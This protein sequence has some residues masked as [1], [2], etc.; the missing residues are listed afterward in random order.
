MPT[1]V[2]RIAEPANQAD[3]KTQEEMAR[4]LNTRAVFARPGPLLQIVFMNACFA[5]KAS[6]RGK[7]WQQSTDVTPVVRERLL[8]QT[9]RH[10]VRNVLR[11][12]FNTN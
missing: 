8:Q 1:A 3:T 4:P 2:I 10:R 5:P 12:G 11:A 7:I 9:Q 6:I